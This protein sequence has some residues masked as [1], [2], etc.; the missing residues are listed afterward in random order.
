MMKN[1]IPAISPMLLAGALAVCACTS[2]GAQVSLKTVVELAQRNSTA[3]RMAQADV[4][5][6]R[7]VLSQSKD[8]TIPSLVF[9]TGLPVF[10]EVGFTGQPPS[11]WSAT[12]ESLVFSIPQKHYIDAANS[13][14][15]A[16]GGS[17]VAS[18]CEDAKAGRGDAV[19]PL[20]WQ[21][22]FSV[23]CD[24]LPLAGQQGL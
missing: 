20:G 10:P 19:R 24:L 21:A 15:R 12:I 1:H 17:P 16:A 22:R 9:N 5:K 13:G 8:V 2:A 3:V 23:R 4:I 6:A 7:A 18:V 14:L 11:I